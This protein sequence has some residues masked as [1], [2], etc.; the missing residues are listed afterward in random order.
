MITIW[1]D[2]YGYVDFMATCDIKVI[3]EQGR[4]EDYR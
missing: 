4:D 3:D 1:V 2:K